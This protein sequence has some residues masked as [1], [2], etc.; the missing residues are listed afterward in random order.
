MYLRILLNHNSN[1]DKNIARKKKFLS[2]S[3][4]MHLLKINVHLQLTST[5]LQVHCMQNG[6]NLM[7]IL[8]NSRYANWS[9]P[10]YLENVNHNCQ[11]WEFLGSITCCCS[12]QITRESSGN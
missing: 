5:K 11:F 7:C 1:G 4:A 3:I 9:K 10:V 2:S 8:E 6:Q 12:G